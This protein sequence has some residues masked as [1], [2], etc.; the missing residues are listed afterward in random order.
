MI[1][2]ARTIADEVVDRPQRYQNI[3]EQLAGLTGFRSLLGSHPDWPD[4]Q[5]RLALF[6]A[7][8]DVC[9]ASVPLREAALAHVETGTEVNNDLLLDAFGDA[10]RS[11]REQ[12]KN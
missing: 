3:P 7:L 10:A 1:E 8:G 9:L 4:S 11:F 2:I 6:R 12:M 5:Q